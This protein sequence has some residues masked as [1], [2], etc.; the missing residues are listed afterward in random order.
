MQADLWSCF[1]EQRI[2]AV[3]NNDRDGPRAKNEKI[4]AKLP[5]MFNPLKNDT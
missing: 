1:R 2:V 3:T 4:L 5:S